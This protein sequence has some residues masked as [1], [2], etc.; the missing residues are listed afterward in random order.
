M[1]IP[2]ST[3]LLALAACTTTPPA[4]DDTAGPT[5]AWADHPVA[6]HLVA[7]GWVPEGPDALARPG[8]ALLANGRAAF[9]IQSPADP[10]TYYHYGGTPIDAVPLE[11]CTQTAPEQFGELGFTPGRLDLLDVPRSVLRQFRGETME[12]VDVG[13]PGRAAHVR[14]TGSDGPFWLVDYTLT[15][16][17]ATSGTPRPLSSPFP[18]VW[19]VDYVLPPDEPVLHI[20]VSATNTSDTPVDVIAGAI[21]FPSARTPQIAWGS[22][23]TSFGGF[24]LRTDVPWL[25][26]GNAD[27]GHALTIDDDV[28]A[29]TD[30]SGANVL[31]GTGQVL[32]GDL[33]V[34]PA[35]SATET[36]SMQL[37]LAV[38][39]AWTHDAVAALL[40]EDDTRTVAGRVEGAGPTSL[41]EVEAQRS[42]GSWGRVDRVAVADDGTFRAELPTTWP[43]RLVASDGD[44]DPADP[45]EVP[46]DGADDLTLTLGPVGTLEVEVTDGR[47]PMPAR[48]TLDRD[49][50]GSRVL[51]V[52]PGGLT[53]ALPEGTWT[54]HL[55]RGFEHA[56]ATREVTIAAG[57]PTRVEVEMPR[58]VDTRGWISVDGHVHASPSADSDVLPELRFATA[59]T[60]GLDVMVQTD[61]EAIVDL[62]P[63]LQASP[64]SGHVQTVLGEEV[65]ATIPEH[66]NMWGVRVGPEDGPRGNPVV[67]YQ[68][69]IAELYAAMRERGAGVV[70]LNHPSW[71]NDI[72]YDVVTGELGETD[73]TRWGLAPGAAL[74][75]WDLDAIELQNGFKFIFGDG[76][77][78][79]SDSLFRAWSSFFNLGHR[80]TAVGVSDVHGRDRP[81]DARTY[82]PVLDDSLDAF[83]EDPM[84]AAVVDGRAV[85]STGAFLE[86]QARAAGTTAGL[87]DT[88]VTADG[89]LQLDLDVQ[90]LPGIRV[91]RA[92]VFANCD[93]VAVVDATAPDDVLKLDTTLSLDLEADAWI[94][95]AAFGSGAYPRGLAQPPAHVARAISNPIFV[96]VDG[97]GRFDAPGGK[98]CDLGDAVPTRD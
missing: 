87:G 64:W 74:W 26:T 10:R 63:V 23:D 30:V 92:V 3:V 55:T 34:G 47:L 38:G 59:A 21:L 93:A 29:F 69:D 50:G 25:A 86:V 56:P 35:G 45:V 49:D 66:L 84:I 61:H 27:G 80:V 71:M 15:A 76:A 19:T 58:V 95:V 46:A 65:T 68:R 72:R 96:D 85:V 37:R 7:G 5:C 41:V 81:G 98:V 75:S 40:A 18:L 20:T 39:A 90:A 4:D 83:L 48:L 54:A 62:S 9:V 52:P 91:D 79:G 60:E 94:S 43:L 1:R 73:P 53:A 70:Q 88:L 77:Q 8:D 11:G 24:R 44:A 82:V 22:G 2:V 97:N 12:I 78:P 36:A 6:R 14:V 42:D 57:T 33:S 89:R 31:L 67:W 32:D 17:A 51:F 13:G 28:A 16:S